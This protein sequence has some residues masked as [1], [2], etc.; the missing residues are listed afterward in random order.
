MTESYM[1]A[2]ASSPDQDHLVLA[3]IHQE[4]LIF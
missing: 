1:I 4:Q 3:W 2:N